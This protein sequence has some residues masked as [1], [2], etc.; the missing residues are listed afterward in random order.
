MDQIRANRGFMKSS[1]A[2]LPGGQSDQSKGVPEPPLELPHDPRAETIPLPAPSRNVLSNNDLHACMKNR[3]SRRR[4]TNESLSQ[5]ELSFL[6]WA[7]QGVEEILGDDY[8]T[9]RTAPSGG[10]RHAFETYLVVNRVN[11]IRPGVYRYLPLSHELL[12]L[13]SEP[14]LRE[15]VFR[16][17][18]GQKF[19]ADGVVIF[20][21][22]CVPYRG[23]WRYTIAAHKIMLLDA[24][25]LCQNLYLACEAMGTGTCAIG[26]YDQEAVD[27]LL[28]LDGEDEFVVY[29]A[30]VGKIPSK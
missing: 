24:G 29:L 10:A 30:P 7:T 8:A 12:F 9:L 15:Q 14:S 2:A 26:A 6:L 28:R 27:Q 5:D 20:F 19:V 13:F 17:T 21:W 18:F 3:R 4:W 1:F 23:E 25:H 22:S 16:A 11:G